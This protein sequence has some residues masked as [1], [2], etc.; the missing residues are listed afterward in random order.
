MAERLFDTVRTFRNVRF[1][2]SFLLRSSTED[3]VIFLCRSPIG[4]AYSGRWSEFG[5]HGTVRCENACGQRFTIYIENATGAGPPEMDIFTLATVTSRGVAI[6][7]QRGNSPGSIS[8]SPPMRGD[9]GPQSFRLVSITAGRSLTPGSNPGA[10]QDGVTI[11]VSFDQPTNRALLPLTGVIKQQIDALF[12]FDKVLGAD[13]TGTWTNCTVLQGKDPP[14]GCSNLVIKVTNATGA[15]P[16]TVN[17]LEATLLFSG[18]LRDYP[19][20]CV[21]GVGVSGQ[22]LENFGPSGIRIVKLVAADTALVRSGVTKGD[23]ITLTFNIPTDRCV[24]C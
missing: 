16:P 6:R 20:A 9:F 24:A 23:S 1:C 21:P 5:S 3:L 10:Y 4:S 22:I 19:A 18:G 12:S 13:Y 7:G 17:G 2:C 8:T 14:G 11:D 15:S